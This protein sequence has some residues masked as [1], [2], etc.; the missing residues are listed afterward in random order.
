MF[1]EMSL[2]AS[3]LNA[4]E[5]G[6]VAEN[7]QSDT[8]KTVAGGFRWLAAQNYGEKATAAATDA[9]MLMN[10][11]LAQAQVINTG[12]AEIKDVYG[13]YMV[14]NLR[15]LP[16]GVDG[17]VN[18]LNSM[19]GMAIPTIEV[20]LA[21]VVPGLS[22]EACDAV[23]G[24]W[25]R[26]KDEA[27]SSIRT[28]FMLPGWLADNADA[29]LAATKANKGQP[30]T[31]SQMWDVLTGGGLG[32]MPGSIKKGGMGLLLD[33]VQA[34]YQ[35]LVKTAV[36]DMPAQQAANLLQS[37]Y[38]THLPL[39]KLIALAKPDGGELD[40]SDIHENL[41]MS[42]LRSYDAHTA[43]GLCTD[44]R[45]QAPQALL[46]FQRADGQRMTVHPQWIPD[47]D[48]NPN[49]QIF[50]DIIGFWRGMTQSDAQ[51]RR[52]GQAFSQAS[53]IMPRVMSQAF[54]G[55]QYDEHGNFAMTAEARDDGTIV[56]DIGTPP[57]APVALHEQF[58]IRSDGTHECTAFNMHRGQAE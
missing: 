58:V 28:G 8:A 7:L 44:F 42:S 4:Q 36:P 32:K 18:K 48:N 19:S 22:D 52:L 54:P 49:N 40:K 30:P 20:E 55:V 3:D 13:D 34:G 53:L 47:E 26:Y 2:R 5:F 51:L 31:I 12:N 9:P 17:A 46:T 43:Y 37:F 29:V 56:V 33:V 38:G 57:D 11:F 35:R 50:Q 15:A 1:A 25:N 10:A 27:E 45:R 14:P 39:P 6:Y 21:N 41:G 24:A 16:G 23:R